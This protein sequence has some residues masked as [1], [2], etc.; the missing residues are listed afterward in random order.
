M[1]AKD[2]KDP[3]KPQFDRI[4]VVAHSLGTIV[5]YDVLSYLFARRNTQ[6]DVA[7]L[8]ADPDQP[9]RAALEAYLQKKH[10]EGGK[11]VDLPP[12]D[13]NPLIDAAREEWLAQGGSWRISDFITLGSPL[14]HAEFLLAFDADDLAEDQ[15]RRIYPTCPPT[16][17]RDLTT[18]DWRMCYRGLGDDMKDVELTETGEPRIPHYAAMFGYTKWVNIFSPKRNILTG[19]LVSGPVRALFGS[20]EPKYEGKVQ[21][22]LRAATDI[23]V[24]PPLKG[25][26][27]GALCPGKRRFVTHNNYWSMKPK[28]ASER[29]SSPSS[30]ASHSG[31]SRRLAHRQNQDPA[32]G[33]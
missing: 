26:D 30:A 17:E 11:T 3:E 10:A 25:G 6:I 16:M 14:T 31:A 12:E 29:C 13:F 32:R 9:A 15:Q 8:Q 20:R 7:S 1:D 19:D 28:H 24:M 5:A 23:A 27:H 4:T 18:E 22:R 2:E 33:A 21:P